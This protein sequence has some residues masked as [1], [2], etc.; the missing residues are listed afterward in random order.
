MVSDPM[1]AP[2]GT[3]AHCANQVPLFSF[4]EAPKSALKG[5]AVYMRLLGD[6]RAR[7]AFVGDVR[8]RD[9]PH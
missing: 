1:D 7:V 9:Y 2:Y 6:G 4:S 3:D 8:D 5:P